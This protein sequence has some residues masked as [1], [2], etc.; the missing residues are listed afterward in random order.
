M[1]SGALII[2]C[3]CYTLMPPLEPKCSSNETT[4]LPNLLECFFT[5]LIIF[6][7]HRCHSPT[8][9]YKFLFQSFDF[10]F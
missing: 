9:T 5:T 10:D 1:P 4:S 6:K 3:T 7:R 8:W 2:P